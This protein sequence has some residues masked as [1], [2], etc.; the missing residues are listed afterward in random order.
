MATRFTT[1]PRL[2]AVTVGG[3]MVSAQ[4]VTAPPAQGCPPG[5]VEDTVTRMC[6]SQSGQ[7]DTDGGAGGPCLPG[8]LGN[9]V[10][11]LQNASSGPA[12]GNPAVPCGFGPD[13]GY[14]CGYWPAPPDWRP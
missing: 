11:T 2:L 9:C 8:R 1:R 6:W 5:Q 13:S 3:L 12:A 7:G 14:P 10:G 4:L